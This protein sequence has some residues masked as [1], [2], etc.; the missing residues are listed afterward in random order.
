MIEKRYQVRP[1]VREYVLSRL[2]EERKTEI[3]LKSAN[4]AKNYEERLETAFSESHYGGMGLEQA[5]V[6]EAAKYNNYNRNLLLLVKTMILQIHHLAQ[7][8]KMAE[9]A[10]IVKKIQ[11]I[12][13]SIE[14]ALKMPPEFHLTLLDAGSELDRVS[15][16]FLR[17][18]RYE[19]AIVGWDTAINAFHAANVELRSAL[20][21]DK[22]VEVLEQI[23]DYRKALEKQKRSLRIWR[24]L[25]DFPRMAASALNLA[26]L[27]HLLGQPKKA[28]KE[29]SNVIGFLGSGLTPMEKA[30]LLDQQGIALRELGKY[31][32]ALDKFD[33]SISIKQRLNRPMAEAITWKEK[34]LT[35]FAMDK[36]EDAAKC[37][38]Y[39]LQVEHSI[40]ERSRVANQLRAEA[41]EFEV[42]QLYPEALGRF[43]K[44]FEIA[45]SVQSELCDQLKADVQRVEAKLQSSKTE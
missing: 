4:Y 13:S 28:L 6:L 45:L 36:V 31:E 10:E 21:L 38:H 15:D 8:G 18:G 35:L 39:A 42:R 24:K 29:A 3:H 25:R 7:A 37:F 11:G 17:N 44:A 33:Q 9:V 20:V 12:L 41:L 43:R 1:L 23:S 27:Y 26:R 14:P 16:R 19:D 22:Q 5:G 32:D 34:G 30:M 2:T 40:D